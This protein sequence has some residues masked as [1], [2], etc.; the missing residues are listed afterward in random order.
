MLSIYMDRYGHITGVGQ[1][2]ELTASWRLMERLPPTSS[3]LLQIRGEWSD[4][5]F[6]ALLTQLPKL[7]ACGMAHRQ[8]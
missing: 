5:V 7:A 2:Q 3:M 8:S 6:V 4:L 1:F